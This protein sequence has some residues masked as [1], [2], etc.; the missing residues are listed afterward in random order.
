MLIELNSKGLE[1]SDVG[2]DWS[3]IIKEEKTVKVEM[4]VKEVWIKM[5]STVRN[6]AKTI[7]REICF[8]HPSNMNFQE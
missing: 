4:S 5:K 3:K 8:D 6:L 7:A 1:K 2:S